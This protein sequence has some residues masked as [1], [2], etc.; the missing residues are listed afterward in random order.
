MGF[1][2]IVPATNRTPLSLAYSIALGFPDLPQLLLSRGDRGHA[3]HSKELSATA[4]I[5]AWSPRHVHWSSR[6]RILNRCLESHLNSPKSDRRP[7]P[8]GAKLCCW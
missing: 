2:I 7:Y 6:S 4:P 3:S 5:A 1:F 8:V